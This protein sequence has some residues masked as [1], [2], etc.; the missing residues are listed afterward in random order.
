MIWKFSERISAELVSFVVSVI[1]ARILIPEDYSVVGIVAIFFSF[2]E[3][4]ISGGFNSALIQKKDVDETDYSSVMLLSLAISGVVYFILFFCAGWISRI[5]KQDLIV[6]V[7][8]VMGLVLFINAY[9]SVLSAYVSNRLEFKKYFAS[10]IGGTVVSAIVGIIMAYKGFG[11]WALVAQQMTNSL[12]DT[13][14]LSVT[15]GYKPAFRISFK[16]LKSLFDYGGKI[17]LSSIISV[18]YDEIKPLI[19]GIRFSGTDLAFY[20]KGESFPRLL[21]ASISDTIS[22]VLFPVISKVQDEAESVRNMTR[23][24]I[25]ITSFIVFP[26]MVGLMVIADNFVIVILT[27]KWIPIVP[28]IRIFCFSYMFNI[29]QVANLQAIK[30]I[31]RSDIFLKLEII[32]KLSYLGIILGFVLLSSSPVI[33]AM[34]TIVTTIVSTIANT[35]PNRKLIGYRYRYQIMDLLPNLVSS[36]VMG[37]GVYLLGLIQIDKLVVMIIQIV[38]GIA[39]YYAIGLISK[40]RNLRFLLD[41]VG[42]YSAGIRKREKGG[43]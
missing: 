24:F 5:Y 9:K 43:I 32:K 11:P 25:G 10:T 3:V 2:S 37:I 17:Y 29:I 20:N 31:G 34:S 27:E 12:I 41:I 28:Y 18:I 36:I 38:S 23:R 14:I 8:R 26:M 1:L 6:P 13:L 22:A 40:N 39:I 16:R 42:Q 30:A 19:V 7:L 35:Y 21:N 33:L 4:L 15:T